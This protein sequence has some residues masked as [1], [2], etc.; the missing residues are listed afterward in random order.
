MTHIE[1]IAHIEQI[2]QRGQ[3]ERIE[4]KGNSRTKY[5]TSD[6]SSK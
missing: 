2:E 6:I 3:K 1:Q 4:Q 5:D